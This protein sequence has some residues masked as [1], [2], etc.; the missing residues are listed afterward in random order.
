M[1][2]RPAS[3][4]VEIVCPECGKKLPVIG[5]TLLRKCPFCKAEYSEEELAEMNN[6]LSGGVPAGAPGI[7]G[8]PGTPG[9]SGAPK[10]PSAPKAP[11]M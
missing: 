4:Q 7:P 2:F 5:N 8:A 11:G 6:K 9:T 10:A 3:A 1:C